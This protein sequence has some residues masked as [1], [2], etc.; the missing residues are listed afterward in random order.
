MLRWL[1]R[2]LRPPL[3]AGEPYLS[4]PTPENLY[5]LLKRR[6]PVCGLAPPEWLEGLAAR[7]AVCAR[8]TAHYHADEKDRTAFRVNRMR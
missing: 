5:A 6:C 3:P 7:D 4:D 8:C 1:K 2:K